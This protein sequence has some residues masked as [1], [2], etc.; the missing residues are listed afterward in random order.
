MTCEALGGKAEVRKVGYKGQP[1]HTDRELVRRQGRRCPGCSDT[2]SVTVVPKKASEIHI[3]STTHFGALFPGNS[4]K[5]SS[6][7][8]YTGLIFSL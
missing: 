1:L 7:F 4:P 2:T 3:P 6:I 5:L 8:D